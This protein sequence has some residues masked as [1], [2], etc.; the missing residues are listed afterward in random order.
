M[1]ARSNSRKERKKHKMEL[2][3]WIDRLAP[4]RQKMPLAVRAKVTVGALVILAPIYGLASLLPS[5]KSFAAIAVYCATVVGG[6][7]LYLDVRRG[8][9]DWHYCQSVRTLVGGCLVAAA[10]VWF[11]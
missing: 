5:G 2:I 11:F 3:K 10:V 1:G 7:A 9:T 4:K 6:T 8:T